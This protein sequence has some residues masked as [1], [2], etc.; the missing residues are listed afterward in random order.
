MQTKPDELS[1]QERLKVVNFLQTHPVGVLSS[2]DS[3]GNPHA[4][5]IYFSASDDLVIS[6]TTKQDTVKHANLTAN[7]HV[8]LVAYEAKDQA[9]VQISG[10]AM[11]VKGG[12]EVQKIYHG[13][14]KAAKQTGDDVVPPVAKIM[15][16]PFVAYNIEVDNIWMT[17][18]G[19]GDSFA[20]A[21]RASTEPADDLEDPA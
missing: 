12:S 20:R 2:V 11:E 3:R 21:L 10:R 6:F 9:A 1:H 8:M 13:T 17:E 5:P 15:G 18:Y 4:S 14:L 7:N 19:H 16:G